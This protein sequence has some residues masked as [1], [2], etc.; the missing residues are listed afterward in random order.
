[1]ESNNQMTGNLSEE[2]ALHLAVRSGN[3]QTVAELLKS[4]ICPNIQNSVREMPLHLACRPG[5]KKIV[6]LADRLEILKLLWENGARINAKAGQRKE[7]AL[8]I[9]VKFQQVEVVSF[10]LQSGANANARDKDER[11][12]LHL[13]VFSTTVS[14]SEA[15]VQ[16]LVQRGANLHAQD[17]RW[18]TPLIEA[19]CSGNVDVAKLLLKAGIAK[20]LHSIFVNC[21]TSSAQIDYR[22]RLGLTALFYA[23]ETQNPIMTRLLLD[24]KANPQIQ[25]QRKRSTPLHFVAGSGRYYT[26]VDDSANRS[27]V[28]AQILLENGANVD[29]VDIG[30][31]TAL[32]IAV[33]TKDEKLAKVLIEAGAQVNA[34]DEYGNTPL[35]VLLLTAQEDCC[36]EDRLERMAALLIDRGVNVDEQNDNQET[37]LHFALF[38]GNPVIVNLL[39]DHNAALSTLWHTQKGSLPF[40]HESPACN[41]GPEVCGDNIEEA[42]TPMNVAAALGHTNVVQLLLNCGVDVEEE[43]FTGSHDVLK[44]PLYFAVKNKRYE[45]AKMLLDAGCKINRSVLHNTTVLHVAISQAS[46]ALTYLLMEYGADCTFKDVYG[47]TALSC[48]VEYERESLGKVARILIMYHVK[49]AFQNAKISD[50]DSETIRSKKWLQELKSGC[51]E[52]LVKMKESILCENFSMYALLTKSVFSLAVCLGNEKIVEYFM[53]EDV[54]GKYPIYCDMLRI[55][56]DL[57]LKRKEL[58]NSARSALDLVFRNIVKELGYETLP[59]IVVQKI[60]DYCNLRDLSKI[61]DILK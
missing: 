52:E 24:H 32:H 30:G 46:V 2:E 19:A 54:E 37:P 56:F 36:N 4:D 17:S 61:T 18:R 50:D 6:E 14:N 5:D 28:I 35:H 47:R 20:L 45:V 41:Y 60:L 11:S 58:L 57:A 38:R 55:R 21:L 34:R 16:L 23:C 22:N 3:V 42:F 53:V 25:D 40:L 15:L 12:P 39:L 9:A 48:A 44:T 26:F 59:D 51:E 27:H 8:H 33:D 10:L 13:V 29:A 31:S 7:T 43:N 1:M 49:Q